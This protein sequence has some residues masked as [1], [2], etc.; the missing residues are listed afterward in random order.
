M[1][2]VDMVMG[3]RVDMVVVGRR[4][5]MVVVGRRV[6]MGQMVDMVAVGSRVDKAC[7]VDDEKCMESCSSNHRFSSSHHTFVSFVRIMYL[8]FPIVNNSM[9][10]SALHQKIARDWMT[11]NVVDDDVWMDAFLD[12]FFVLSPASVHFDEDHL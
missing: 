6:D 8:S 3:Q 2:N 4:G 11:I 5:D 12:L 1:A 7:E 9:P 10:R